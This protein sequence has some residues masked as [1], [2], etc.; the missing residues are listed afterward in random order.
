MFIQGW[1]EQ[2]RLWSRYEKN[3]FYQPNLKYPVNYSKNM[4]KSE[5]I[6]WELDENYDYVQWDYH[7]YYC[8]IYWYKILITKT[9]PIRYINCKL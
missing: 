8:F 7:F 9:E 6:G 2:S 4:E 5:T 3:L 1:Y